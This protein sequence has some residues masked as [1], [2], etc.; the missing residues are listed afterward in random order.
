MTDSSMSPEAVAAAGKLLKQL[1]DN[2][3]AER[4]INIREQARTAKVGA[5]YSELSSLFLEPTKHAARINE[6]KR[7]LRQL[8]EEGI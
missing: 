5:L 4:E 3:M 7:E 1:S 6:I 2:A 8:G